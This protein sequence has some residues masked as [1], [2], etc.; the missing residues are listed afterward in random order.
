MYTCTAGKCATEADY[1]HPKLQVPLCM[2]CFKSSQ[3]ALLTNTRPPLAPPFPPLSSPFSPI[4]GYEERKEEGLA[5]NGK[6]DKE[7]N[8]KEEGGGIDEDDDNCIWCGHSDG[9]NLF[10]CDT[11]FSVFCETCCSKN[12]SS[13]AVEAIRAAHPWSCFICLP[14]DYLKTIQLPSDKI[15][16]NLETVYSHL[17]YT[18]FLSFNCGFFFPFI[19]ETLYLSFFFWYDHYLTEM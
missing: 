15:L 6:D 5:L 2:R 12:F 14:T 3:E 19:Y 16:L 10:I 13:S 8:H 18:L 17:L 4:Q 9:A 11:C 1:I 7:G